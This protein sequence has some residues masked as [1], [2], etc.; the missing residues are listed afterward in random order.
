MFKP[1]GTLVKEALIDKHT[2]ASGSVWDVAFSK[3]RERVNI[4]DRQSLEVLT[5][6]GNGGRQPG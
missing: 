3:D 6:F 1:D 2:R 4:L 5:S